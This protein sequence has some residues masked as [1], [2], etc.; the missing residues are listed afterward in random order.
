MLLIGYLMFAVFAPFALSFMASFAAFALACIAFV[1]RAFDFLKSGHWVHSACDVTA[2]LSL[3]G[4]N[5]PDACHQFSSSWAGVNYLLNQGLGQM[6]ANLFALLVS[7]ALFLAGALVFVGLSAL[8][9]KFA[10]LLD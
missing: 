1:A 10:A 3:N 4:F 6:D 5:V 2:Y 7:A 8:A 9:Q